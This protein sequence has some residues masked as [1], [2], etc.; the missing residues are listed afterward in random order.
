LLATVSF[1]A[2]YSRFFSPAVQASGGIRSVAVLTDWQVGESVP[3]FSQRRSAYVP[4]GPPAELSAPLDAAPLAA[5][6]GE[7][8]PVAGF[9]QLVRPPPR[10]R[11]RQS[12]SPAVR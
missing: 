2:L 9:L 12:A 8:E 1:F 10:T 7:A 4:H 5:D 11:V 6:C 3:A